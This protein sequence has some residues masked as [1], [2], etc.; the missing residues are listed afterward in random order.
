[1][2]EYSAITL[3]MLE[4]SVCLFHGICFDFGCLGV[5]WFEEMKFV[6]VVEMPL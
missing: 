2:S 1:M 6:V 3:L 4:N 5:R